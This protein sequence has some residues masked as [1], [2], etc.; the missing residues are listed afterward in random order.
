MKCRILNPTLEW[1]ESMVYATAVG[2]VVAVLMRFSFSADSGV[3]DL[4]LDASA[5]RPDAALF[6][7]PDAR[8]E[9]PHVVYNGGRG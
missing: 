6:A 5:A 7:G 1:A 8:I 2:A 4:V 9:R 3:R